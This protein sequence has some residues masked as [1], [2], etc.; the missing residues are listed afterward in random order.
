[1]SCELG[2]DERA[3]PCQRDAH[4]C[5]T[6][7]EP[8]HWENPCLSYTVQLDGSPRSGL[9]A[10]QL[11][12]LAADAFSVW[13]HANCPAGGTP[14]FSARFQ[15]F[16]SCDRK[17][18]VCGG[19]SKNDNVVMVHD[20]DW[21]Y[22]STAIGVTTPSGG[23]D[24]G[25]VFDADVELN[26]VNNTFTTGDPT[27]GGTSISY[28]LTHELG[29]FLGL[30]HSDV[31]GALMLANYQTLSRGAD[32]LSADDVAAICAAFPPGPPLTCPDVGGPAYDACQLEPGDAPKCP[33][34]S[35]SQ[36]SCACRAAPRGSH[37]GLFGLAAALT[38]LLPL[39]LRRRRRVR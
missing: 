35:V 5:V 1:M 9:D 25:Q 20:R 2:E 29:H 31:Q 33:I 10:D 18:A 3:E 19:V 13:E 37:D 16:V 22:A 15:G 26:A 12:A 14:R 4:N 8:L 36:A 34:G 27:T 7:G 23:V 17:E 11:Q 38:G 30:A 6:E 24:S 32:L 21:P 28:T 39:R